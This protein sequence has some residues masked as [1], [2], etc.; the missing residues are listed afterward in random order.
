MHVKEYPFMPSR[1]SWT[2]LASAGGLALLVAA[3]LTSAQTDTGPE[4][5]S[6]QPSYSPF[7]VAQADVPAPPT[8]GDDTQGPPGAEV[9]TQGP[10][11]EAFAKPT[12]LN[13]EPGEIIKK[14]P[15]DP[16]QEVPPAQKPDGDNIVWINGYWAWDDDRNDFLWVSGLYRNAPPGQTWTPGYWQQVADGF[17]WSP[18]FWVAAD[19][20]EVQYLPQPPESLEQ[21]PQTPAPSDNHFWVPGSWVYQNVNYVWQPGYWTVARPNWIWVAPHYVWTPGGFVFIGGYWDFVLAHRGCLFAPL[22]FPQPVYLAPAY[23][24]TPQVVI[25]VGTFDDCLFVRPAYCHYYFGDYFAAR[26]AGLGFRPFFSVGFNVGNVNVGIGYGYDP[27]CT[28]YRWAGTRRDPHWL[29]H[30]QEHFDLLRKNENLRPPRTLVA[31]QQLIQQNKAKNINI[32]NTNIT[33]NVT[34]TIINNNTT[35]AAPITQVAKDPGKA[36]TDFKFHN[37]SQTERKELADKGRE[38]QKVT[39]ERSQIERKDI[40]GG[41]GGIGAAADG[42]T[43]GEG[44]RDNG[45]GPALTTNK[46]KLPTAAASKTKLA[47]ASQDQGSGGE[48]QGKGADNQSKGGGPG[49]SGRFPGGN[50]IGQNA[51]DQGQTGQTGQTGTQDRTGRGGRGQ[52][53][54][55]LGQGALG[56]GQTGQTGGQPGGPNRTGQSNIG[57]GVF[58]SDQQDTRSRIDGGAKNQGK[59]NG[60]STNTTRD[61]ST[62]VFPGGAGSSGPTGPINPGQGS[63]NPTIRSQQRLDGFQ[64]G[65]GSGQGAP[66]GNPNLGGAGPIIRSQPRLDGSQGGGQGGGGQ[67]GRGQGAGGQGGGQGSGQGA[68]GQ[69]GGRATGGGPPPGQ[70]KGKDKD[71]DDKGKSSDNTAPRSNVVLRPSVGPDARSFVTSEPKSQ[72]STGDSATNSRN[73]TTKNPLPNQRI[74]DFAA[75]Q[76]PGISPGPTAGGPLAQDN[77]PKSDARERSIVPN[78][79]Q[80]DLPNR[81]PIPGGQPPTPQS[82]YLTKYDYQSMIDRGR[83]LSIG[84]SAANNSAAANDGYDRVKTKDPIVSNPIGRTNSG[85]TGYGYGRTGPTTYGAPRGPTGPTVPTAS[86]IGAPSQSG[87]MSQFTSGITAPS[88]SGITAPMASGITAQMQS[89]ISSQMSSGIS[90]PMKSGLSSLTSGGPRSAGSYINPGSVQNLAQ[91]T[92]GA[93]I[94]DS[95]DRTYDPR[96]GQ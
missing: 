2:I 46:L 68:G 11:H 39:L 19:R 8:P 34:N 62:G 71:K 31:Q 3:S 30:R 72:D 15:P 14:R 13:P 76:L 17:Q 77:L 83:S 51:L 43:T 40:A 92:S 28:Y 45:K 35:I 58:D 95:S 88:L 33:N 61:R 93:R 6:A 36:G 89:G 90:A 1:T 24:Y 79:Q 37:V 22:Y 56:Q 20:Q 80:S 94:T 47:G 18:G 41:R 55:T 65:A 29:A 74:N 38:L 64:G 12:G 57:R 84:Q 53:G 78:N 27:L 52:G 10:I 73:E 7:A 23:V 60:Q 26:Y 96:R 86:G 5:P 21:G 32:N 16:V 67:G 70:Q 82:S 69:G 91:P 81:F 49:R 4:L 87:I 50:A 75:R 59:G 42:A 85:P 66:G 44:G 54:T 25:N 48:G 9:L 63:G